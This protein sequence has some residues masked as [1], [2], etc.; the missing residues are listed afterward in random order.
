MRRIAARSR[1]T[2][3]SHPF[4]WVLGRHPGQGL[5][6]WLP[7]AATTVSTHVLLLSLGGA[8]PARRLA[9]LFSRS[10]QKGAPRDTAAAVSSQPTTAASQAS[11]E[12]AGRACAFHPI[13]RASCVTLPIPVCTARAAS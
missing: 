2:R 4:N 1:G 3:T 5:V 11:G 10:N 9:T 6:I 7:S 13:G 8:P 12:L